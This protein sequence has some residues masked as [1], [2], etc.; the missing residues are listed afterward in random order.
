MAF[1][2]SESQYVVQKNVLFGVVG[3][4]GVVAETG[5]VMVT[6]GQSVVVDQVMECVHSN[7][8]YPL[9]EGVTLDENFRLPGH[10]LRRKDFLEDVEQVIAFWG[11]ENLGG[12][13]TVAVMMKMQRCYLCAVGYH[14]ARGIRSLYLEILLITFVRYHLPVC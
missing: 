5:H 11:F 12:P 14:Y 13:E 7:G 1:L 6:V 9:S 3:R 10:N 4:T 2:V 8:M